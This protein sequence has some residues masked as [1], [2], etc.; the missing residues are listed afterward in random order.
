MKTFIGKGEWDKE[1]LLAKSGSVVARS[2]SFRG[3]QGVYQ[4]DYLTNADQVIPD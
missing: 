4:A 1:V 3:W 2:F